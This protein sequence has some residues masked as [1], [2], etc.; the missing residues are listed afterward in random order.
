MHTF[1]VWGSVCQGHCIKLLTGA[2]P[3]KVPLISKDFVALLGSTPQ[4]ILPHSLLHCVCMR[5]CVHVC[6]R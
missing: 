6:V 4:L 2:R 5:V 3:A 1:S